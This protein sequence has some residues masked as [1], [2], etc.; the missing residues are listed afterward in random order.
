MRR[1][2]CIKDRWSSPSLLDRGTNSHKWNTI[3]RWESLWPIHQA[4]IIDSLKMCNKGLCLFGVAEVKLATHL[5]KYLAPSSMASKEPPTVASSAYNT[6]VPLYHTS[7]RDIIRARSYKML[8]WRLCNMILRIIML[9][10]HRSIKR[11]ARLCRIK[12]LNEQAWCQ[13]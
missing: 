12:E 3:T 11:L 6:I 2:L 10:L 5:I 4:G 8:K 9:L 1:L 13:K 7:R